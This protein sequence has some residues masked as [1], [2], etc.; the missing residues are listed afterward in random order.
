MLLSSSDE[1]L[2]ACLPTSPYLRAARCGRRSAAREVAGH[3]SGRSGRRRGGGGADATGGEGQGPRAPVARAVS[4]RP[5]RGLVAVGVALRRLE[6][7]V[8]E[9]AGAAHLDAAV[10]ALVAQ[11]RAI[12]RRV[13][14]ARAAAQPRAEEDEQR[15]EGSTAKGAERGDHRERRRLARRRRGRR[16]QRRRRRVRDAAAVAGAGEAAEAELRARDGAKLEP[17]P[18]RLAAAA[19]P[20]RLG[21]RLGYR[22]RAG[23]RRRRRRRRRVRGRRRRRLRRV[24]HAA[25][26]TDRAAQL[27]QLR[28][29][30]PAEV[31]PVGAGPEAA[32]VPARP[33]EVGRGRQLLQ[34]GRRAA[35]A[36]RRWCRRE[37]PGV[38]ARRVR[39]SRDGGVGGVRLRHC[40]ARRGLRRGGG[41]CFFWFFSF[42]FGEW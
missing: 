15:D 11:P 40:S 25:A 4:T 19:L 9:G 41:F 37:G 34:R 33:S 32:N 24:Q 20:A 5:A 42:F 3:L 1:L 16:R 8:G 28:A 23:R 13:H 30:D 12:P 31:E 10:H 35:G 38:L 6:L 29:A 14:A 17:V 7:V 2:T 21:P 26:L 27:R 36:T 18:A 39:P 22:G